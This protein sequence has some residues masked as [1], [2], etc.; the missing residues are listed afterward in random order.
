MFTTTVWTFPSSRQVSVSQ[1]VNQIL[2]VSGD[3]TLGEHVASIFRRTP[4]LGANR[5]FLRIDESHP[6]DAPESVTHPSRVLS[7]TIRLANIG[8]FEEPY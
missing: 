1:P 5:P 8:D 3:G 7:A 6:L 4:A 2:K